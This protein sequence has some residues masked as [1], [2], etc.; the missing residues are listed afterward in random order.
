MCTFILTDVNECVV[1]NGGC[2]GNC[3]NTEGGFEC[4]CIVGY[5]LD[6]DRKRCS[7]INAPK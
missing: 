1:S 7:G 2:S 4:S 5:T 3:T 6:S